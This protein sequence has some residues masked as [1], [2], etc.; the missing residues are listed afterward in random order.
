MKYTSV[1]I[2]SE[3]SFVRPVREAEKLIR[4]KYNQDEIHISYT[5]RRINLSLG[6]LEED[7]TKILNANEEGK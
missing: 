1:G 6:V 5:E 7:V 3:E 4:E 2:F